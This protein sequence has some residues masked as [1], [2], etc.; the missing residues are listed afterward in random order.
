M[1]SLQGTYEFMSRK[2]LAT[3]RTKKPYLHSPVDDFESFYYTAQWAVAFNDGANGRRYDGFDLQQFRE[4]IAGRERELSNAM[5]RDDLRPI[6][7]EMEYGSFFAQSLYLL[8]PWRLKLSELSSDWDSVLDNA[9]LLDGEAKEKYLD[10]NFLIYGYRGVGEYLKLL[11]E[12][13]ASLQR[14]V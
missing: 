3:V 7:S 8:T 12:H 1:A 13:R 11:H 4:I 10:L 2:L 14:A 9:A 6:R 5:V